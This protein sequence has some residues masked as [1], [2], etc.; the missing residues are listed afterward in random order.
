MAVDDHLSGVAGVVG[1][2]CGAGPVNRPALARMAAYALVVFV[3]AAGMWRVE[4]T[5]DKAHA[6][7]EAAQRALDQLERETEV[8]AARQCINA[9]EGRRGV[10]SLIDG[11]VAASTSADPARV[12]A[13]REDMARRLPDPECD[14]AAAEATIADIGG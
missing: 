5:A 6:A 7:A 4:T 9:W 3:S 13:F 14:L 11:L 10:R 12:K 2:G 1:V 8:G